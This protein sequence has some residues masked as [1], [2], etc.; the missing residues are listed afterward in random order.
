M[1][2]ETERCILKPP[3]PDDAEALTQFYLENKA[4]FAPWDPI[5]PTGF[6]TIQHWKAKTAEHQQEYLSGK[7]FR[8]RIFLKQT[9][10]L[11]GLINYTNFERGA[12]QNCRLGYK[13]ASRH[14]GQGLMYETVLASLTYV[15]QELNI[16]RVEANYIPE[17]RRSA[18]LLKR[19]G[20]QELGISKTHL[21]IKG[22]WRDH[23]M[24]YKLSEQWQ[25]TEA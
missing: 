3:S 11:I 13:I 7:S 18:Q 8:L 21:R 25:E 23:Q 5:P 15:F 10:E 4:H 17:N 19:L 24:S 6:Y 12:F 16:H 22:E 20:F 1:H 14:E 9:Q 2:L